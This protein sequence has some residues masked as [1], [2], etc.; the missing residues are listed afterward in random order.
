MS[1]SSLDHLDTPF[2]PPS[3]LLSAF[4]TLSSPST[5]AL[6]INIAP[7]Y[8]PKKRISCACT[9]VIRTKFSVSAKCAFSCSS[10]AWRCAYWR[11]L[12][13]D[14]EVFGPEAEEETREVGLLFV[15][16]IL[17]IKLVIRPGGR[18]KDSR[19]RRGS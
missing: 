19:G 6:P 10:C 13:E 16:D 7:T 4:T 11:F 8:P 12:L 15:V 5:L 3:W 1:T 9:A 14:I 2:S 18:S 17:V